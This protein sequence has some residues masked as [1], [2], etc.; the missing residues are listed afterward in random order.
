MGGNRRN[1]LTILSY[2]KNDVKVEGKVVSCARRIKWDGLRKKI[3]RTWRKI[4]YEGRIKMK[5]NVTKKNVAA[6]RFLR[7]FH[8]C[9]YEV[10]EKNIQP[11]FWNITKYIPYYYGQKKMRAG[12]ESALQ[13]KKSKSLLATRIKN[14]CKNVLTHVM[15][16]KLKVAMWR[17]EYE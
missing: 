14:F 11:W 10:S 15:R 6:F 17:D 2:G 16:I 9:S 5:C 7:D 3:D 13:K 12:L 1:V 8:F 4:C